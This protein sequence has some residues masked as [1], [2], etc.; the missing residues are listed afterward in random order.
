MQGGTGSGLGRS[1]VLR[2]WSQTRTAHKALE[3][4]LGYGCGAYCGYCVL[5]PVPLTIN[6]DR[7]ED[8]ARPG[9]STGQ[10][11][12]FSVGFD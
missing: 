12:Y 8:G 5:H 9:V 4:D 6:R 2:L 1:I 11:P 10:T 7:E 3:T